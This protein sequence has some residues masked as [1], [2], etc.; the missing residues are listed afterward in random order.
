[1][2]MRDTA[3]HRLHRALSF[4]AKVPRLPYCVFLVNGIQMLV[5]GEK[6]NKKQTGTELKS[7]A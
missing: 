6:K 3:P 5:P 1:M 4:V 7:Q 2:D